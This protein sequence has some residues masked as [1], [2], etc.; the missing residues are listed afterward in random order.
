MLSLNKEGI[1]SLP[2]FVCLSLAGSA[3]GQGLRAAL[4]PACRQ[5]LLQLGEGSSGPSPKSVEVAAQPRWRMLW[6]LMS[7]PLAVLV[8]VDLTMWALVLVLDTWVERPCRRCANAT[9]VLWVCATSLLVLVLLLASQLLLPSGLRPLLLQAA[10]RNMLPLF[11]VANLMTGAVNLSMDTLRVSDFAARGLVAT[12]L[13][14][15]CALLAC[16][17]TRSI[18]LRV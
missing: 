9:Y 18:K 14:V 11:L 15:L 8:A 4:Q 3:L 5:V 7:G 16:L 1:T 2:G 10:S 17:G 6:P 12:Y 13:G